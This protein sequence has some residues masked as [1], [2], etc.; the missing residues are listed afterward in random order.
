MGL[1]YL[2]THGFCSSAREFDQ[3][4]PLLPYESIAITLPGHGTEPGH[5]S[6]VQW[7]DWTRHTTT[8]VNA[9]HDDVILI[10]SSM[11]SL[12]SAYVAAQ[13]DERVVGLVMV[14]PYVFS[15]DRRSQFTNAIRPFR[16]LPNVKN[17]RIRNFTEHPE[18]NYSEFPVHAYLEFDTLISRAKQKMKHI[19]VPTLVISSRQDPTAAEPASTSFVVK[20]IPQVTGISLDV[21]YHGLLRPPLEHRNTLEIIAN[22]IE[23]FT[24]SL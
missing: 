12:V 23:K 22:G 13:G 20:N 10:G 3:L 24:S 2:C 21:P 5:L 1:R 15:N 16:Y 9:I 19:A 18:T 14:A 17:R 4:R 8:S 7:Q 6:Y 11:G